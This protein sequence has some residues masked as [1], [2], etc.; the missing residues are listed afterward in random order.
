MKKIGGIVLMLAAA[1]IFFFNV[2]DY[3]TLVAITLLI[4][5]ISLVAA[6]RRAPA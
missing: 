5:G 3:Y 4:V 1:V 6:T 2:T